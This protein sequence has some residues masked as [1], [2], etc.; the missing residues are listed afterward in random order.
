MLLIEEAGTGLAPTGGGRT[1][2]APVLG[3]IS[4]V[5]L[6]GSAPSGGVELQSEDLRCGGVA[7]MRGGG[8]PVALS[9][10]PAPLSDELE[11]SLALIGV[12]WGGLLFKGTP[13]CMGRPPMG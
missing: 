12:L 8:A 1:G 10:P 9:S 4:Q 2:R 13:P 11:R 3:E 7:S 6:R 5:P